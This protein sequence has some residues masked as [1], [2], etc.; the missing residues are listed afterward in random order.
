MPTRYLSSENLHQK[1]L[2]IPRIVY[3]NRRILINVSFISR[4]VSQWN[5]RS[6]YQLA[7]AFFSD[8]FSL[9]LEKKNN[10]A[11]FSC[12]LCKPH[13]MAHHA[14]STHHVVPPWVTPEMIESSQFHLISSWGKGQICVFSPVFH[15]HGSQHTTSVWPHLIC[16]IPYTTNKRVLW[17]YSEYPEPTQ[18]VVFYE[19][20]VLASTS[21][22]RYEQCNSE[23]E[24]D[25]QWPT[26]HYTQI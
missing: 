21:K 19:M 12:Y 14:F 5:N 11:M 16:F 22:K 10:L 2:G 7:T 9:S 18:G 17:E 1:V 24:K 26:E 23:S 8:S 3:A 4:H 6:K 25:K 13:T 20:V 15:H